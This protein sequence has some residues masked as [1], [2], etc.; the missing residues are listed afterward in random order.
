MA[1]F[2]KFTRNMFP[3][4]LKLD[5]GKILLHDQE[6]E[7]VDQIGMSRFYR[8]DYW[9]GFYH[10]ATIKNQHICTNFSILG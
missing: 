7:L 1:V 8:S 3:K 2:L 6:T 4:I 9:M 10:S 5:Q